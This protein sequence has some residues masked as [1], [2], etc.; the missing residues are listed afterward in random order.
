MDE[1]T[2][3]NTS[4]IELTDLSKRYPKLVAVDQ[5]NLTVKKGEIFGFLGPN[6]A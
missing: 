2:L 5:L 4:A 3:M 6:G 1:T